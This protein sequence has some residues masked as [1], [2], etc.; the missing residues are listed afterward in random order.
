VWPFVFKGNPSKSDLKF[1]YGGKIRSA[2]ETVKET[3]I[4]AKIAS[5][6]ELI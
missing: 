3:A 1:V 2:S 6:R 5:D 4:I